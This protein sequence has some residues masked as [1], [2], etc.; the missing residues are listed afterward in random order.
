MNEISRLAKTH[1]LVGISSS[2][3]AYRND[4]YAN[5]V[6][7]MWFDA[8]DL[9]RTG[10]FRGI[11]VNSQF[12]KQ[13]CQRRYTSVRKN[14]YQIERK[15]DMKKRIGRSPDLA[16]AFIYLC[17]M[18]IRS[19]LFDNEL[20]KVRTI[21]DVSEEIQEEADKAR[22]PDEFRRLMGAPVEAEDEMV[23]S[24]YESDYNELF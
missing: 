22:A 20:E 24:S 4:K 3:A 2:G 14:Y 15:R 5:K 16:D 6:T 7:E 10:L 17:S 19:G 12:V 1:D 8:R 23:F 9:V 11:D 18:L 13:L 21:K